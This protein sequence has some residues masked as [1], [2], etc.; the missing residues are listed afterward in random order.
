MATKESGSSKETGKSVTKRG[1]EQA[2]AANALKS[3]KKVTV[4]DVALTGDVEK[5]SAKAGVGKTGAIKTKSAARPL[6]ARTQPLPT[7]TST[8]PARPLRRP[9]PLAAKTT[10]TN[11]SAAKT[12]KSLKQVKPAETRSA[13]NA[14]VIETSVEQP[15]LAPTPEMLK[16][17]RRACKAS[18]SMSKQNGKTAK[19]AGSFIAKPIKNGKKY[20]VDL[21]VHSPGTE[22][23]FSVGGVDP[24]PAVVSLAK[25][26]GLDIIAVTDYF[27]ASYID[28]VRRAAERTKMAVIPGVTLRCAIGNCREVYM[29]ALFPETLTGSDIFALLEEL[30]VP[31]EM[32][33]HGDY[34]LDTPFDTILS[35]V[36][37]R[38]GVVIPSRIDKTPYRLLSATALINDYGF[39]AFDLVYPD[40]TEYFQ[41]RWPGGEFTILT[42]SKA[43]ALGQIGSRVAKLRMVEPGFEG[44]KA[45]VKRRVP[46]PAAGQD[47]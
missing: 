15:L 46:N 18:R 42:F 21:R 10:A 23:Y 45:L 7:S 12:S 14:T 16:N 26:K 41:D 25:V 36:E 43:N 8:R 1:A 28:I 19:V 2:R 37:N 6:A 9:P 20:L 17:F 24:G 35:A 5:R 13:T 4:V 34:C 40:N 39:H 29:L 30:G 3:K 33:G 31:R 22:G 44:I 47:S 32:Y 11:S 38:G 27:N